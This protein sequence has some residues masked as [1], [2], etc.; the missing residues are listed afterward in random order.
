VAGSSI[1]RNDRTLLAV[2]SSDRARKMKAGSH[3]R[4]RNSR[5]PAVKRR[6]LGAMATRALGWSFLNTALTKFGL[7]GFGVLL[8]RLLGPQQYGTVAVAMTALLAVL[9]FNELGVS[10]AI[11][12]WPDDPNEIVPT[13]ATISVFSSVLLYIGAFLGA[14]SFAAAMGS[15]AST[16]VIRVMTLMIITNGIASVPSAVL[17]RNFKQGHQ[18]IADQAHGWIGVIVS[19]ALA[20]KGFGAMSLAIGQV[21]A[22]ITGGILMLIFS[23]VPFRFGFNKSKA[24]KL[25]K[26]GLPLAGSSLVVFLVGNVDNFI[27]GHTLGPKALG[28]YVLAWSIASLPVNL[29][30]QPVRSVAPALFARLQGNPEAMRTGFASLAGLLGAITLPVCLAMGGCALPLVTFIY[31]G[32][33]TGASQALLW[34]AA[35]AALRIMFELSYDYFVVLAK[36]RVVLTVQIGWLIILVPALIAGA[37]FYGIRGVAMAGFAVAAA[38]VLPWY[39]YEL[40]HAGIGIS[41]LAKRFWLSLML[42]AGAGV[43]SHGVAKVIPNDFGVIAISGTIGLLVIVFLCYTMRHPLG[44]LRRVLNAHDEDQSV[45][46]AAVTSEADPA[47]DEQTVVPVTNQGDVGSDPIPPEKFTTRFGRRLPQRPAAP[48]IPLH[49]I[50]PQVAEQDNITLPVFYNTVAF[51]GWD[52]VSSTQGMSPNARNRSI[53]ATMPNLPPADGQSQERFRP[54]NPLRQEKDRHGNCEQSRRSPPLA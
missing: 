25:L 3:R 42:A 34:L 10:L 5:R 23:P 49:I 53:A 8:A 35:L 28:F 52:P 27:A 39:L 37:H 48:T 30:S 14:P 15:P 18:M 43:A 9:S 7:T 11:V 41:T 44:E 17:Q 20:L 54:Q 19:V 51:L 29:F 32:K 40:G 38:V 33:W 16:P 4:D 13:V 36:S 1:Q 22:A 12:R 26:F 45:D 6:G 47:A 21:C 31:G 46:P 24:R 2:T 50:V